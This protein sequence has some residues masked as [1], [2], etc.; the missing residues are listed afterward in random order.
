MRATG[1]PESVRVLGYR[2]ETDESIE[3]GCRRIAHEQLDKAFRELD[4]DDLDV[5]R[6]VHQVRKRCKKLRGLA[7]L[8]RSALGDDYVDTNVHFRDAARRLSSIR[9][10]E[11]ILECLDDLI[12]HFEDVIDLS[13]FESIR[14][15]LACRR[16]RVAT[17]DIENR[18][19]RFRGEMA[20]GR[21]IVDRWRL[22]EDEEE[23]PTIAGGLAKTYRRG[24]DALARAYDSRSPERFHEWRKRVKYH[25]YHMRILRNVW[26]R[27]LDARVD[28]LDRLGDM[29]GD[30]HDL[31]VLGAQV[32][33]SARLSETS[34]DVES[35]LGLAN[36]RRR[37][38]EE[39]ARPLGER[40]FAD[41]A[42]A[43]TKRF[44]QYWN[45]MRRANT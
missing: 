45:A 31:F 40:L 22:D 26:R 36:Q 41:T 30:A 6:T 13:A 20:Q 32:E 14:E 3:R 23:W 16:D 33:S 11:A 12:G 4:D 24:R 7:R 21:D 29:L 27:P 15:E 10:A 2:I 18:L 17:G 35:L 34:R 1:V 8:A 44:G 5:H 19:D 25:W 38:L 39:K 37:I 28:A 43:F 9:D 42:G